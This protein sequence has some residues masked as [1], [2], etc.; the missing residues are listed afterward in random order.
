MKKS[1]DSIGPST[2]FQPD[3]KVNR[4]PSNVNLDQRRYGD[5]P[6]A[7]PDK[8]AINAFQRCGLARGN[9]RSMPTLGSD[10]NRI[11]M[12]SARLNPAKKNREAVGRLRADSSNQNA[13]MIKVNDG[14]SVSKLSPVP[15]LL[16]PSGKMPTKKGENASNELE[17]TAGNRPTDIAAAKNRKTGP[18]ELMSAVVTHAAQML[19]QTKKTP[20][21]ISESKGG[22]K[23]NSE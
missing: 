6:A 2:C 17:S 11:R 1:N 18:R 5:K 12:Q 8:E 13:T 16:K 14:E 9:S 4:K 19:C 15:S 22:L 10:P 3:R 23:S 21:N 20:P 7:S